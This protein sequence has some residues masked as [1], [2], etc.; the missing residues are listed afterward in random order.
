MQSSP[1]YP[2]PAPQDEFRY[3][4]YSPEFAAN[5]HSW[6]EHMRATGQSLVPVELAPGVP[7][8]LVIRHKTA[9]RILNDPQH[10]P[11]DP[12]EWQGTVPQD[13]PVLAMMGYLPAA[14]YS[15]GLEHARYRGASAFS[16]DGVNVNGLMPMIENIAV[17]LI[18]TFCERGRADLM[19]D[20]AFKLVLEVLNRICGCPED[21]GK[22]VADGMTKR[23]DQDR[24]L[25]KEGMLELKQALMELIQLKR[26]KPGD[27]ATTRLVQHSSGLDDTEVW[28]QLMSFYG[29]GFEL[30]RNLIVNTLLMMLTDPRYKDNSGRN[31]ATMTA[32]DEVLF[33][34]PPMANF[35]TTY[36]RQP[37]SLGDDG[38]VPAHQPVVISLA[39]CNNDPEIRDAIH[40]G[41]GGAHSGNRSHLAWSIGP[42]AC[43]AKP[44]A[45]HVT[46]YAIDEVLNA[47]P[48]MEVMQPPDKLL[49][50]PGP[51]TRGLVTLPVGFAPVP[52]MIVP[53]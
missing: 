30:Q 11:S 16:I 12:R 3:P 31:L 21:I 19:G 10:F 27:D 24:A 39:A 48:D 42:H 50:R 46:Q 28:A 40:E 17:T 26:D 14:R 22:K 43:P 1:T 47:L 34:D 44:L 7:A 29:A 15:I 41:P 45:Y 53:A 9:V 49:W 52:P 8:M 25:A 38:W 35:C 32:I 37:T 36:P 33:N 18:N 4:L 2:G 5:P 23:F 20:Y 6:Y 13:S 51:F